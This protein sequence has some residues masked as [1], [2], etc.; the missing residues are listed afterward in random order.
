MITYQQFDIY[1]YSKS[2]AYTEQEETNGPL[3]E[4]FPDMCLNEN[5]CS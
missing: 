3:D 4:L 2:Y 5:Y 1:M